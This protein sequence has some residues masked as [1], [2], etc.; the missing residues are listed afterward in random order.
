MRKFPILGAALLAAMP[1]PAATVGA[2]PQIEKAPAA[3]AM[4][5][6]RLMS[7][8]DL[9]IA[10]ELR[11]YDKNFVA[12]LR[13][14]SE[15]KSLDD[16]FPGLIDAMHKASRDLVGEATGRTV[17][18]IHM[19]VARLIETDF[20]AAEIAELSDFYRSQI[21]Q[22]TIHQM[23]ASSD[24]SQLYQQAVED[25]DFKLTEKQIAGIVRDSAQKTAESFTAEEQTQMILFM[26]KRSFLK[27]AKVQPAIQKILADAFNAPD[28]EFEKRIDEAMA[29]AIDQHIVRFEMS[30]AKREA[31]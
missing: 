22:K 14:N 5:V 13:S 24:T 18:R 15:L 31:E 25:P 30:G 17:D 8:R 12:S 23:A 28:P 2:D 3:E 27:L 29:T 19:A 7:P 4:V 20:T 10:M 26:A 6:A 11:E 21:G 16:E 9:L 1:L